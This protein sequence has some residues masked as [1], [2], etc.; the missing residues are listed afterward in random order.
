MLC[1]WTPLG[2]ELNDNKAHRALQNPALFTSEHYRQAAF[3]VLVG[4]GIRAIVSIPVSC[5]GLG[6]LAVIDALS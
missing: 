5:A 1:S 4:I 2:N 6:K 3:A